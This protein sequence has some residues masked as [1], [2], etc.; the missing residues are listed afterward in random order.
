[1]QLKPEKHLYEYAVMRY[2]PDVERGEFVNVG[3]IMLCKRQRWLKM[4]VELPEDKL[5]LYRCPHSIEEIERQLKGFT[6]LATD[7]IM[8]DRNKLAEF[9]AEERF[10]WIT[11]QKS[12]CLQTSRPHPGMTADLEAT[13]NKLFATLV[14]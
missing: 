3:L 6:D 1:M 12:A 14:E 9:P 7:S 10:R 13:F 2:V 5:A 8:A 4:K 11:A